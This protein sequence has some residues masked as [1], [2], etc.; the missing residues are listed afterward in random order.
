MSD[1]CHS[2]EESF[3]WNS[4]SL[5]FVGSRIFSSTAMDQSRM[6]FLV[7]RVPIPN[8][9]ST[10]IRRPSLPP[11]ATQDQTNPTP[12]QPEHVHH[13]PSAQNE[14]EFGDNPLPDNVAPERQQQSASEDPQQNSLGQTL[15]NLVGALDALNNKLSSMERT[16]QA[17]QDQL[18]R[19]QQNLAPSMAGQPPTV[20]PCPNGLEQWNDLSIFQQPSVWPGNTEPP[21]MAN[22]N[23]GGQW[24]TVPPVM[25]NGNNARSWAGGNIGQ[26]VF[27]NPAV[28]TVPHSSRLPNVSLTAAF[29]V[30]KP[31][32]KGD[33]EQSHPVEFLQDVDRYVESIR[34]EPNCKLPFV[35]SCL[36]GEART[37]ARGFGYLL[38][39][40]DQFR[41]HFLQQYWGQRAQRLVRE[42]IMYGNYAA[43]TPS[44]MADYFLAL[45]TKA[46]HLD[47]APSELELVLHLTQHFPRSVGARLSNCSDI[48]SAYTLLQTEDHHNNT[49]NRNVLRPRN[50]TN[51]PKPMQNANTSSRPWRGQQNNNNDGQWHRNVRAT[52]T[53]LEDDGSAEVHSVANIFVGSDELLAEDDVSGQPKHEKSPLIEARI[54]SL[55]KLVL[56]D[57]GSELSCIDKALY[58][59]L[60]SRGIPLG[61]FPVQNTTIQGAYGK[62][63]MTISN[64]VF[65]PV[66]IQ[67]ETVDVCLAVVDELCTPLIFGMDTLHYLKAQMDFQCRKVCLTLNGQ[68]IVLPFCAGEWGQDRG[69]LQMCR[70]EVGD[71]SALP[72]SDLVSGSP[73]D[74]DFVRSEE[75]QR[76]LDSLLEE[77]SD[78]FSDVPGLTT[79]YEHE[80]RVTND[81]GYNQKQYP[82]PYRYINKVRDQIDKME[83]WGIISRAPTAFIN[84]LVVTM[85][86]SG[87]VRVCLDARRL[88]TVMEK[89]NEKPPDVQ[90]IVQKF[91]DIRIFSLIDLTSSYWQIPIKPGH[92]KYTGFLF[93]TRS[94]VFNV[95]PFGLCTA[96][97]SFS[98]AMDVILGPEILEFIEKYLD[99]LLVKSSSFNEHLE[100]LRK[101]FTR[102][103][104]AGLTISASKSEFCKTRLK[105]LGHIV[106]QNGV[107]ID[108][109]KVSAIQQFPEPCDQKSLKSFLGLASYVSRFTPQYAAIAKPLYIL[110]RAEMIWEWSEVEKEAFNAVKHLFL[111]HTTLRYPLMDKEFCVQTD[112][113]YQG[114]GAMLFQWDNQN[115]RMVISYASRLLQAAENNYTATELEALAVVWSL[116]KWRQYL[117]GS[118][119]TV[120]TDHKALVFLKRCQLLN[121]RLTRWIL[122]LQ[123]F[124]FDVQY[125]RGKDN[126]IAD[127]L[128]RYPE[129]S[130]TTPLRPNRQFVIARLTPEEKSFRQLMRQLPMHQEADD[131]LRSIYQK[132][133]AGIHGFQ[134]GEYTK[135]DGVH[136]KN[137]L[138]VSAKF[139]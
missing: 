94:Y 123:Q 20:A 24:A 22:I 19:M 31:S 35:L 66:Y 124:N 112:S 111:R 27:V 100:H 21:P 113:S 18:Q 104:N 13:A 101:L 70:I 47:T 76:K 36:E 4:S 106:G 138:R 54:D 1:S 116:N 75:E 78:I 79:E 38:V 97:A 137:R 25:L 40:Y 84:P 34:L 93:E 110:L 39:N 55:V 129:G 17:Q 7:P 46:R 120:Y 37:W 8:M 59:E 26:N 63:K 118:H 41:F 122:F 73:L 81:V 10:P 88:N 119:F 67:N 5:V 105:F 134:T 74:G 60:K 6:P 58:V 103:R 115:E 56:L 85:K 45:I 53:E 96:V 42:E 135:V 30:P 109:D 2:E 91:S 50:D 61:E 133:D 23:H 72:S 90:Q 107:S 108:P 57:S 62:R 51:Q 43:I 69:C 86:K 99:D 98:R 65:V 48:Q 114:L 89:D 87:E 139:C 80:V 3:K 52:V 130:Q 121:G 12:R 71:D 16:Q 102:L 95:L 125:C 29:D 82:I 28:N 32:F 49:Y 15:S 14:Q 11:V 77:F 126:E 44:K 92:R 128:S 117:L 136:T 132:A 33:L 9:G 83:E 131:D 64:Q 127:A 68:E